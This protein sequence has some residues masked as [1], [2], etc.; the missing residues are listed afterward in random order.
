MHFHAPIWTVLRDRAQLVVLAHEPD[1]VRPGGRWDQPEL[2]SAGAVVTSIASAS[3]RAGWHPV[4][5]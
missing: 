4:A 1:L 5:A 2:A 3:R